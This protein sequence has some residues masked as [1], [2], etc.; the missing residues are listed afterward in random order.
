MRTTFHHVI[1]LVFASICLS[2]IGCTPVAETANDQPT[3]IVYGL[4]LAPSG[5]D[6]HLNGSAELGIPLRSVYDTLIYRDTIS[7]DFVPGL[8]LE[9]TVTPDALDYHFILRQDVTFHDGTAFNA[10]AVRTNFTRIL[11]P[12]NNSIKAVGLL[13]PISEV[14]VTSEFAITLRLNEP[15]APLLDGLAQPYLGIAS[16]TALAQWDNATYQFHQVGTGPYKFVEYLVNDRLVLE[17]NPDYTWGPSVTE[18]SAVPAVERIVFRF[19]EDVA[20]RG[21]A[22]RSGQADIMGE[23][24]PTDAQ[25]LAQ[26]GDIT[27]LPTSIPGQPQ[28]FMLNTLKAP[29]SSEAVRQALIYATDRQ[30]IVQ[31]VFQG[32][33]P[34]AYGPITSAT[35]FYSPEVEITYNYDPVQAVALF[36]STGW[37]DSDDDGWRDEDGDNLEIILVVPPWGQT[38]DVAQLIENQWETTLNVQTTIQQIPSFPALVDAAQSGEYHAISLNFFGLDPVLLN[39]F[40]MSGGSR[41][42]SRVADA[43]L[44]ARLLSAQRNADPETRATLYAEIQERIMLQALIVPIRENVNLNGT[45]PGIQ[46]LH[47]DAQGWFPYL[48]DLALGF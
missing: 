33:T 47:F 24:P 45:G 42:W 35:Q 40:Y 26:R 1:I 15:F 34:I 32:Y 20:S 8:A 13:G 3:E 9:W 46:G 4:T 27:L 18:N 6:P 23:L 21:E 2:L 14:I 30:A 25:D 31:T 19:F 28:Q 37:I 36:N 43:E 44:D 11:D 17:R 10:E 16:P 5:I 48:T 22:L 39:E 7:G 41:N 38:P 12:A 29:T